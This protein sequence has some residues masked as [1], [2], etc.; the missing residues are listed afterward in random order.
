MAFIKAVQFSPDSTQRLTIVLF[1]PK[2]V[3]L[4]GKFIPKSSLV[5]E[6]DLMERLAFQ[7][8]KVLQ[9]SEKSEVCDFQ[10]D[11][12]LNLSCR[13]FFARFARLNTTA[14]WTIIM[15]VFDGIESL[16]N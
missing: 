2:F 3:T 8:K 16:K 14:E 4:V 11:L 12:F 6:N 5:D 15:S 10:P 13:S 9:H 1:N 7:S